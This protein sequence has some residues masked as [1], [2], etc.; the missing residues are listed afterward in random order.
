MVRP[1]PFFLTAFHSWLTPPPPGSNAAKSSYDAFQSLCEQAGVARIALLRH[2]KTSPAP[3]GGVDFDRL[4]TSEGRDQAMEAGSSF[5]RELKP[6]YSSLLVSP[7]PRTMETAKLFLQTSE[8]VRCK[9]E[10]IQ[11]LYDGTMQPKVQYLIADGFCLSSFCH[12]Y[13]NPVFVFIFMSG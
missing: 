4:L 5:G 7:A 12:D 2:G 10:P 13:L 6:F 3:Q 8:A 9:L 11:N 1:T